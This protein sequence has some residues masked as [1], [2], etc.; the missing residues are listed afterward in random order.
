MLR[1]LTPHA[2]NIYDPDRRELV[3]TID[4]E[5]GPY[6][7]VEFTQELPPIDVDNFIVRVGGADVLIP[8][9]YVARNGHRVVDLPPRE[10]GVTL[11]VSRLVAEHST[12]DDLVFPHGEVRDDNGR[13]IGCTR[14]AEIHYTTPVGAIVTGIGA[15]DGND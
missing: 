3:L 9:A 1:N 13:I 15:V 14:L 8:V 7:R 11:I 2:I 10:P 4:P 12:R 6:P 5:P